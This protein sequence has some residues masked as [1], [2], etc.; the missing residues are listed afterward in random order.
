M[1]ELYEV[2]ERYRVAEKRLSELQKRNV[3]KPFNLDSME[4]W[5]D[6][7]RTERTLEV[8][9][10]VIESTLPQKDNT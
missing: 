1:R 8:L 6:Q 4:D 9:H 2:V 7:L 10:W 5:I 3:E